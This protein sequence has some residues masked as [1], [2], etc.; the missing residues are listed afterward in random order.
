MN[1][2]LL[3]QLHSLCAQALRA[4]PE[5][6]PDPVVHALGYVV[7]LSALGETELVPRSSLAPLVKMGKRALLVLGSSALKSAADRD[8]SDAA[9]DRHALH[10]VTDLVRAGVAILEARTS[11]ALEQSVVATTLHPASATLAR[12]LEGNADG[13]TAGRNGL[14]VMHCERCQK[15]LR[16]LPAASASL[17]LS[18][19]VVADAPMVL[20]ASPIAQVRSP[21][22][23]I[24]VAHRTTPEVEAV[25]F[26][27]IDVRRLA[28]YSSD[29]TPLRMVAPGLTTEDAR[30]G[31]WIGRLDHDVHEIAATLHYAKKSVKWN[32]KLARNT[33]ETKPKKKTAPSARKPKAR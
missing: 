16:A 4:K 27:D 21:A 25:L 26:Q 24:R 20:A 17:S 11:A 6:D 29:D 22:G 5:Q 31:Y 30:A 7:W 1:P 9:S 23:G 32:V 10:Q 19:H 28:I 33:N 13:L 14:H 3:E 15:L 8:D 18:P 12:M 2:Q